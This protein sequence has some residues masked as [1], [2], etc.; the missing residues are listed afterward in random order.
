MYM[1][2][3]AIGTLHQNSHRLHPNLRVYGCSVGAFAALLVLL[4]LKGVVSIDEIEHEL[5][6]A[7]GGTERFQSDFTRLAIPLLETLFH[8]LDG[9]KVLALVNHRLHI[10]VSSAASFEWVFQYKTIHELCHVLM[11]SANLPLISSYDRTYLDGGIRFELRFL[12]I[13]TFILYNLTYFPKSCIVPANET[14][15]KL[16]SY[17][18]DFTSD[19]LSNK[20]G[21][22]DKN[23]HVNENRYNTAV[24]YLMFALHRTLT[25]ENVEWSERLQRLQCLHRS[26]LRPRQSA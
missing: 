25:V 20:R 24:I 6:R 10:G 18:V 5:E 26:S 21:L 14:K 15:R 8:K 13:R 16:V 12:P 23:L 19:Y 2:V 7:L 17:G 1:Y 3:G 11:L 4:V 9:V 22:Y